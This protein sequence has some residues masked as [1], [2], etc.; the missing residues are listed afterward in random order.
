MKNIC[1]LLTKRIR[2]L[3]HRLGYDIIE[4][5]DKHD[6]KR[7]KLYKQYGIDLVFD[8][9]ANEGQFAA[10]L[11]DIGYKGG[12]ISFEPLKD[13]FLKLQA[14]SDADPN[15]EAY[16]YALGDFDGQSRINVSG[17]SQSSSLLDMN[18]EHLKA[19]P[20]SAYFSEEEILVR[21]L[22]SVYDDLVGNSEKRIMLKI[23]TQGYE[24]KVMDGSMNSIS[25]ITGIQ[26]EMSLVEL[27][28]DEVLFES[29]K[30]FIEGLGFSLCLLEPGFQN[31]QTGKLLQVD[32]IFYRLADPDERN[33]QPV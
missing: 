2:R 15:W 18:P 14:R 17:N 31:P 27:Y 28:K 9:G 16:N 29:M 3:L 6:I 12:I 8:V 32:S 5:P 4:F 20:Y 11:R 21:K 7:I 33:I 1:K 23:D 13:A 22:D 26:L 25:K 19:A 10:F 30:H 24:K